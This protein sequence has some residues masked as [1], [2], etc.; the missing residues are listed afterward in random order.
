MAGLGAYHRLGIVIG[1]LSVLL[2]TDD[3]RGIVIKESDEVDGSC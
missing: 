1:V 2:D 3:W